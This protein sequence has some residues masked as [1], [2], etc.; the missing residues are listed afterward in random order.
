M[1]K[2]SDYISG[3]ILERVGDYSTTTLEA[4]KQAQED[5][6]R[7]TVKECANQAYMK[8]IGYEEVPIQLLSGYERGNGFIQKE[9]WT[10]D[11]QS[12]LSVADK[13]IKEL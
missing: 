8:F 1:K 2:A 3:E 5:A 9:G 13:L 7:E 10:I 4:I 12:I 11:T 6:I